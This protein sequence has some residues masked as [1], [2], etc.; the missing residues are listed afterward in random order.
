[1]YPQV[2]LKTIH[3]HQKFDQKKGNYP[4]KWPIFVSHV[5]LYW[6]SKDFGIFGVI[7]LVCQISDGSSPTHYLRSW[8][9]GFELG[10]Q[11]TCTWVWEYRVPSFESTGCT[12]S[13]VLG[14]GYIVSHS[15]THTNSHSL[16][17]C[18][19]LPRSVTPCHSSL[20]PLHQS[21][22]VSLTD[23]FGVGHKP[24]WSKLYLSLIP[25]RLGMNTQLQPW[26]ILWNRPNWV[27]SLTW[28]WN[29]IDWLTR[30]NGLQLYQCILF[31]V[32]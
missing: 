4:T 6:K 24:A 23:W 27:P 22:R 11:G 26:L 28:A 10:V 31:L 17:H 32:L 13:E 30:R 12:I 2:K 3:F 1:M 18:H 15:P 20:A 14:Y 5:V 7:P 21:H 8:G 29:N 16:S 19:S 9:N 25:R